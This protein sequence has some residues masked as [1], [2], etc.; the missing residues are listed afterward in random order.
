MV[1]TVT[2][3]GESEGIGK[4]P[5]AQVTLGAGA[6]PTTSHR[7]SYT[8]PATTSPSGIGKMRTLSGGT[9]EGERERGGVL[10]E[11]IEVERRLC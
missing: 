1:L 3:A 8:L 11:L 5:S 6:A 7:A 2:L 4:V 9:A 10:N